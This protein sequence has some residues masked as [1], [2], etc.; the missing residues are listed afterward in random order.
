MRWASSTATARSDPEVL[1]LWEAQFGDFVNGAQVIIDQFLVAG[2]GQ[3]GRD[4]AL[5]LLLPHGYEG[6]GPGA[7]QRA[8]RAL[9]PGCA[10][11]NIRVANMHHAARSTSTCCGARRCCAEPRPLV[12]MTPKSLLRLS[13]RRLVA[14]RS[15]RGRL[16]ARAGRPAAA[17]RA[18]R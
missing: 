17:G 16:P 11:D 1:V 9:P 18:R 3:V 8:A 5:M 7:L 2:P 12:M 10:E 15:V 6:P 4:P 14:R 13:G